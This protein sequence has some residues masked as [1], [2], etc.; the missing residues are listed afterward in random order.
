MTHASTRTRTLRKFAELPLVLGVVTCVAVLAGFDPV[1]G[2][3]APN[4]LL[5]SGWLVACVILCAI[6]A[7]T[8]A[9]HLAERFGEPVGTIILTLAA[10]TIE[11]AAVCAMMLGSGGSPTV[12]RDSMF[13]VIMVILNALV[14]GCMILGSF[15][16]GE[17]A[18]NP[19][20]SSA[21]LPLLI[22]LGTLTLVLP[23]FTHSSL[24][25]WMSDSM[26]VFIGGGSLVVYL[27]FLW[28]QTSRYRGFFAVGTPA[29]VE[30]AAPL[31]PLGRSIALLLVSLVL[32]VISSKGLA[33]HLPPLLDALHLPQPFAGVVIAAMVLAPEGFAAL[34]A[35]ARG[36]MQRSINVLLGSAIAT[37][38]L[39]VP[40]VLA[41]RAITG[42]DPE[43]GL[44]PPYIVLFALTFIASSLNLARGRVNAIQGL[45]HLLIFISWI[46]TIIDESL[47]PELP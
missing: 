19:D 35:S 15:R 8:H 9:D 2:P 14:G 20:S 5:W 25:G 1:G 31:P 38:G 7:M 13:S 46:A 17:Q 27:A 37:I 33:G 6:R 34:R 42:S 11:V 41:V 43:L 10:I 28:M 44:E 3:T 18:F 24:G 4:N 21:Y 40:A 26:E 16:R 36:D 30:H 47:P 32:V 22:T 23:R 39:T 45:V 29:T 12:A